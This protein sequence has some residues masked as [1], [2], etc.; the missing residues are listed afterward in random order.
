MDKDPTYN[1]TNPYKNPTVLDSRS[2]PYEYEPAERARRI[3]NANDRKY[4]YVRTCMP[5]NNLAEITFFCPQS[6][7]PVSNSD[8]GYISAAFTASAL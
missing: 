6:I 8:T 3:L 4:W 5:C 2:V 7:P 1:A